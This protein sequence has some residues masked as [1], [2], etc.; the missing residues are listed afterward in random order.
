MA[1][2][3]FDKWGLVNRGYVVW[4]LCR[5]IKDLKI[6]HKSIVARVKEARP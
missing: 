4:A 3:D 6:L 1:G 5:K 2:D